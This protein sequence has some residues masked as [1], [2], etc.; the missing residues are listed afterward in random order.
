MSRLE[1]RGRPREDTPL[2]KPTPASSLIPR[3]LLGGACSAGAPLPTPEPQDQ[4]LDFSQL[5]DPLGAWALVHRSRPPEVAVFAVLIEV[6]Y[7]KC[8]DI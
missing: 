2:R 7:F 3:P 4:G 5:G 1:G 8:F 6:W